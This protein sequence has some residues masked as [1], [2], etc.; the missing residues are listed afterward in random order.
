MGRMVGTLADV[1]MFFFLLEKH[2]TLIMSSPFE[3]CK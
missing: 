2:A 1:I 3:K